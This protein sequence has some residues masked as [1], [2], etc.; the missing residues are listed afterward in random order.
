M[1]TFLWELQGLTPTEID[2]GDADVLRF[3]GAD[4]ATGIAVTEYNDTTHVRLAGGT[5]KSDG[6]TPNNNKFISQTGGTGGDS[7]ADWGDGIED[8]DQIATAE[9]ALK[10]TITD[11]ASIT[12]TDAIVYAYNGVT[13]ATPPP[14]LDVRLAEVGDA[15]FTQAEGSGNALALTDSGTPG[16]SHDFFLVPS[17]SPATVGLKSFKIRFEGVIQ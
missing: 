10:V 8:L 6:N 3:A 7:Q 14:N 11:V 16:T 17:V 4:F 15:N 1:A 2:I 12:V 9:A 5:D 13:P